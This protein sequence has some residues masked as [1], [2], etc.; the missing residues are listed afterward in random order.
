MKFVVSVC[1]MSSGFGEEG[2]PG[3]WTRCDSGG[4]GVGARSAKEALNKSHMA[5]TRLCGMGCAKGFDANGH[6]LGEK[7]DKADRPKNLVPKGLQQNRALAALCA[8]PGR[9]TP[10][11]RH[12]PC[13]RH[14]LTVREAP[15]RRRCHL[16]APAIGCCA[17]TCRGKY[18]DFASNAAHGGLVQCFLKF[19]FDA[20]RQ[21]R[22]EYSLFVL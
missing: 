8:S 10:G 17:V 6:S 13:G 16:A 2:C 18:H 3:N 12:T 1:P 11:L 21:M 9:M 22:M 5:A 14:R 19:N 7:P 4:A 15:V 20:P